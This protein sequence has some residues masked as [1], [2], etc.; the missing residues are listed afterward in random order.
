MMQP[1][2]KLAVAGLGNLLLKDDGIGIYLIRA[3]R[4]MKLPEN[5]VL[6]E[7]GTAVFFL[8]SVA[9]EYKNL[10][11]VDAVRGGGKPG[12]VYRLAPEDA[13]LLV[14]SQAERASFLSLH[15][16]RLPYLLSQPGTA[17]LCWRI[18]GVE[19]QTVDYGTGLSSLLS[20]LLP[21]LAAALKQE[22]EEML[23]RLSKAPSPLAGEGRGGGDWQG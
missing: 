2:P 15:D 5:L 4:K 8:H 14:Q 18:F 7:I 17:P 1:R 12:S 9:L 16:F 11:L 20:G 10:L 21:A 3:L 23:L 13:P 22:I 6:F 19:P